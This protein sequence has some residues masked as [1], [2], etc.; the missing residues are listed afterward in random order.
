M[1]QDVDK[2]LYQNF[3]NGDNLSFE[4]I[5]EKYRDQM[6]YVVY[7]YIDNSKI[8]DEIFQNAVSYLMEHKDLYSFNFDV[9]THF[10]MIAKAQ[11][12]KYL[13]ENM[14]TSYEQFDDIIIE[15]YIIN[16]ILSG[17]E[18]SDKIHTMINK[19]DKECR[20]IT[21]LCIL[22]G[23]SY[24]E[25]SKE[26]GK[27]AKKIEKLVKKSRIKLQKKVE[28]MEKESITK[29]PLIRKLFTILVIVTIIFGIVFIMTR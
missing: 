9:K 4:K 19:L 26:T 29:D 11:T 22:E 20:E 17:K 28:K 7:Q 10:F 13:K 27:S 8:D 18:K 12:L 25:A 21:N 5:V 1:E 15:Q 23:M 2:T 6:L 14:A 16:K 24:E 3:L